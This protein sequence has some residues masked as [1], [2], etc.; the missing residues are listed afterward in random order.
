[1]NS[2]VAVSLALLLKYSLEGFAVALVAFYLPKNK[3]P[4]REVVMIG[5]SA[6]LS[7]LLLDVFAPR[8]GSGAR[9]GAGFGIG[10]PLVGYTGSLVEPMQ[11]DVTGDDEESVEDFAP[12]DYEHDRI[13]RQRHEVD[14]DTPNLHVDWPLNSSNNPHDF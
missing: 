3:L 5:L 8:V 9:T 1:M 4:L 7:F 13:P 12:A 14:Y 6:G 11:G 10:A 2:L